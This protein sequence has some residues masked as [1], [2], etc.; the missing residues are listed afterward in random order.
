M[1]GFPGGRMAFDLIG[2]PLMALLTEQVQTV[3]A[4]PFEDW[5][6]KITRAVTLPDLGP[7]PEIEA[8]EWSLDPVARITMDVDQ[9]S[10]TFLGK[11]IAPIGGLSDAVLDRQTNTRRKQRQADRTVEASTPGSSGSFQAHEAATLPAERVKRWYQQGNGEIP[12][13]RMVKVQNVYLRPE[14]ARDFR[15]MNRAMKK[16]IGRVFNVTDGYRTIEIQHCLAGTGPCP[17]GYS[18]KPSLAATAGT[19]NHGWGEA[20]DGDVTDPAVLAWL[21]RRGHEFGFHELTSPVEP[22]HWDWRPDGTYGPPTRSPRSSRPRQVG[23]RSRPQP[24]KPG[25]TGVGE[26]ITPRSSLVAPAFAFS[27]VQDEL[28]GGGREGRG[29]QASTPGAR[30]QS[31]DLST[32]EGIISLAQKMAAAYGWTGRQW[33][34]LRWIIEGRGDVVG[35][36]QW[37]P[38]A[39]NPTSQAAG[40]PQRHPKWH[41]WESEEARKKWMADPRA[42][43]KWFLAYVDQRYGGPMKAWAFKKQAGWY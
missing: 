10:K 29:R 17:P 7:N 33:Q 31:G 30:P 11:P 32:R 28:F 3:E 14:A 9:P 8:E 43:I 34:A 24:A 42:Q 23:R 21:R 41:P 38:K 19:S 18:P 35:E 26:I 37:D 5:L 39:V 25:M 12:L 20:V 4:D 36:S 6:A 22:W 1:G 16:D 13:E 15:A 27:L 2:S 40:I